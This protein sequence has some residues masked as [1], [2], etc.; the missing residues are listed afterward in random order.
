MFI[1]YFF[2]GKSLKFQVIFVSFT[3]IFFLFFTT[4][5]AYTSLKSLKS[6][7][8]NLGLNQLPQMQVL[9]DLKSS[10]E[11]GPR[12]L[13]LALSN[14]QDESERAKYADRALT[15]IDILKS[16]IEKIHT[17]ENSLK[18]QKR[19]I[20]N[21]KKSVEDLQKILPGINEKLNANNKLEDQKIKILLMTEVP[22]ITNVITE[23]VDDLSLAFEK[24][25]EDLIKNSEKQYNIALFQTI[26]VGFIASL[27]SL[28]LALILARKLSIQFGHISKE[29][30]QTGSIVSKTS[31]HYSNSAIELAEDSK[32]QESALTK[33]AAAITEISHIVDL[34]VKSAETAAEI[35]EEIHDLSSKTNE[36]M[37]KLSDAMNSILKFNQRIEKLVSIISEIEARTKVIDD[38]VFKTQLLAFNASIEAA[39]AGE[40][41]R[42]FAIVAQE[43]GKLAQLSGSTA[44]E[45]STIL[46]ASISE[47]NSVT[48]ENKDLVEMGNN[49]T[50]N[51]QSQIHTVIKRI[52]DILKA[53][54]QIVDSSKEQRNGLEQVNNSMSNLNQL[55]K[56][57]TQ[58][59]SE[60]SETSNELKNQSTQ[61]MALV[62]ELRNVVNGS[63]NESSKLINSSSANISKPKLVEPFENNKKLAS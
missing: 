17:S 8:H 62:T 20:D 30:E 15:Q 10:S 24:E 34:N 48:H 2:K 33:T 37:S 28:I 41:G 19:S 29:M 21:L 12:N 49:L 7:L 56:K 6:T 53:N 13:W 36:S 4:V 11:A 47:A 61:L 42:G 43:V 18:E 26:A 9:G 39:R 54:K 51:T 45:I 1:D 32:Q 58:M 31:L 35:A 52:D 22:P 44:S 50:L 23:N 46:E 3:L 14:D 16:S 59:A 63:S 27:L 38:I 55:T 57:S 25:N 60:T 5:I 40:H